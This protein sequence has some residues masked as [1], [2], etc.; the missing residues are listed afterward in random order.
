V[1][2]FVVMKAVVVGKPVV[3]TDWLFIVESVSKV[4]SVD[5]VGCDFVLEMV[6]V[7]TFY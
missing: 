1:E 3:V 5:V 2:S 4:D 6:D 7:A